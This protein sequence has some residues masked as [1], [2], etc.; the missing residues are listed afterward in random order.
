MTGRYVQYYGR[1]NRRKHYITCLGCGNG[2]RK[3]KWV[4]HRRKCEWHLLKMISDSER[5][6][7]AGKELNHA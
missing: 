6:Y 1:P 4:Q 7:G 3:W 5:L 2:A